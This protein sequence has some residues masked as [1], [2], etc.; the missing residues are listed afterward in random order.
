MAPPRG[1]GLGP[2]LQRALEGLGEAERARRSPEPAIFRPSRSAPVAP[3]EPGSSL[4]PLMPWMDDSQGLIETIT[5]ADDE[6]DGDD[7]TEWYSPTPSINPPRPRTRQISYN[8]QTRVMRV[9]FR[10]GGTYDYFAIPGSIWHRVKGVRS[11][12][13]FLDRNVIGRYEFEKVSGF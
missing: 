6:P 7:G 12:G 3:S 1:R 5:I 10:S 4:P 11:P 2:G 13:R 8:R 9:W